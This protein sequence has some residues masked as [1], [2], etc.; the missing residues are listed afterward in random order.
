MNA[1]SIKM[2]ASQNVC[3]GDSPPERTEPDAERERRRGVV[4]IRPIVDGPSVIIGAVM[5]TIVAGVTMVASVMT[6]RAEIGGVGCAGLRLRLRRRGDR[7]DRGRPANHEHACDK[8][9]PD[10][11]PHHG[12][13]LPISTPEITDGNLAGFKARDGIETGP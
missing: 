8:G 6:V 5:R 9:C 3:C 2:N 4:G 1:P 10:Q 13:L 7:T 12:F 11:A